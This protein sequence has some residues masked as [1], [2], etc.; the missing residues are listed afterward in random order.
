[1]HLRQ[2]RPT[3]SKIRLGVENCWVMQNSGQNSRN[4][5]MHFVIA[6][7]ELV[8]P[9]CL[10][11]FLRQA[12]RP[13]K[14]A[15][16]QQGGQKRAFLQQEYRPTPEPLELEGAVAACFYSVC[17]ESMDA[18]LNR[19]SRQSGRWQFRLQC[20]RS[21]ILSTWQSLQ[22]SKS[23]TKWQSLPGH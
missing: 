18:N 21:N 10:R 7:R 17:C 4:P 6:L 13:Q 12:G 23:C 16:L 20:C 19:C 22:S 2:G 1:M 15:F 3:A 8:E 5:L 11:A 9:D 14:R